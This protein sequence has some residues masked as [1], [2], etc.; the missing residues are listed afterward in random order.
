MYVRQQRDADRLREH[1]V[2]QGHQAVAYHAGMDAKHRARAQ[3]R[4]SL[5]LGEHLRP[6]PSLTVP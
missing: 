3:V 4:G 1:L 5:G 6:N 2:S